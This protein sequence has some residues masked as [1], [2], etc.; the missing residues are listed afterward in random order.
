MQKEC[1][2]WLQENPGEHDTQTIANSMGGDLKVIGNALGNLKRKGLIGNRKIDGTNMATW[3][4]IGGEYTGRGGGHHSPAVAKSKPGEKK[5]ERFKKS[6]EELLDAWVGV[7][8]HF[9][10]ED[11]RTELEELRNFKQQVLQ[12]QAGLSKRR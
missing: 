4:S 9:V 3:F 6:V 2:E 7:Q 12:A 8:D 5:L 10:S 1:F 11:M